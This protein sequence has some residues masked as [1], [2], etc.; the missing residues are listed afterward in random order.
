M[1]TSAFILFKSGHSIRIPQLLSD[2]EDICRENSL[3][4]GDVADGYGDLNIVSHCETN[5]NDIMWGEEGSSERDI[6]FDLA[7]EPFDLRN[8]DFEWDSSRQEY[9]KA[10]IA[11]EFYNNE[12]L[13]FKFLYPFLK[14]YPEA[15]LWIEEDW[16]YTLE[17]LEKI[18]NR[19]PFDQE[20]C[21]KDPKTF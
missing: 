10:M 13:L 9:F 21:Y 14:R 17:D 20:W 5:I 2:A 3:Y 7:N 18:A 6:L 12:D 16:F 15:K 4:Y 11:V 19:Q 1:G 8:I